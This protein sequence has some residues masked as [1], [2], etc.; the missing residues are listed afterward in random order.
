[1][2]AFGSDRVRQGDGEQIVLSSRLSK[3]WTPRVARTLTSAE[4]PGTA[5]LWDDRYFEVVSA[6]D[7]KPGGVRYVLEPWGDHQAMR[8]TDR[9]DAESEAFRAGEYR[10]SIRQEAAR[11]TANIAGVFTGNLPAIVQEQLAREL[12]IMAPSLTFISILGTWLIV[13]GLVLGC[14]SYVMHREPMPLFL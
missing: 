14:V 6:Q 2:Q 9:Y 1:M 11:K 12:G 8:V 3:G 10:R 7:L 4:F 5:I 13:G